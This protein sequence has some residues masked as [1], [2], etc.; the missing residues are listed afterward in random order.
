MMPSTEEAMFLKKVFKKNP[1]PKTQENMKSLGC[2]PTS[3]QTN[4]LNDLNPAQNLCDF[5]IAV[6]EVKP[7]NV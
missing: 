2:R 3:G 4:S 5:N 7:R 6:S 1:T